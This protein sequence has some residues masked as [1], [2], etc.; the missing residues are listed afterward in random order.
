MEA[1]EAHRKINAD[2][3]KEL[4]DVIREN[5]K[6]QE[7]QDKRDELRREKQELLDYL[8]GK[9][10]K[11]ENEIKTSEPMCAMTLMI[12]VQELDEMLD[13]IEKSDK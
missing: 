7:M 9:I 6:L 4:A 8:K 10:S 3:R 2:L 11:Y 13:F 12:R 1:N 5:E